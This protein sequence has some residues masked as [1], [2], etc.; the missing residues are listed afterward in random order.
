MKKLLFICT[1]LVVTNLN[2]AQQNIHSKEK[3][4]DEGSGKPGGKELS[5]DQKEF[6]KKKNKIAA[7][8]NDKPKIVSIND[9]LQ[10]KKKVEDKDSWEEGTYIEI[11]DAFLMDAKQQGGEE[12]NCYEADSDPSKGDI[13]INISTEDNIAKKNNDY[14]MVVELTPS[15]KQLHPNFDSELKKLK[16]KKVTVRGYLFYDYDHK[17][18][19]VNY[20]TKCTGKAI[21]RK[22]CWEIHPITFIG[23]SD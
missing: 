7:A 14:F 18:N 11:N 5:K 4:T 9:I 8:P 19:S 3:C 2:Y 6:N 20:C 21:W 22:T 10:G 16:D 12:C 17:Q 13:H 23:P 1:L 15:Y